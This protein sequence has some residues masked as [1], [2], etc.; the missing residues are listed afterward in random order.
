MEE[1]KKDVRGLLQLKEKRKP[2]LL[3]GATVPPQV[4]DFLAT[5]KH[6]FN[7][8]NVAFTRILLFCQ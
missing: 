7:E 2:V 1:F 5:F 4:Y 8:G 6:D 3:A